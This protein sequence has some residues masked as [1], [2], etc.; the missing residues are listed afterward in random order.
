MS[1]ILSREDAL[2]MVD[3]ALGRARSRRIAEDYPVDYHLFDRNEIASA[4]LDA[5]AAERE[6]CARFADLVTLNY[7]FRD[8]P[9]A[10]ANHIADR[11][12]SPERENGNG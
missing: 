6:R 12:R 2:R 9:F 5:V 11:I 1:E 8:V 10:V 3:A 7:T 4:I